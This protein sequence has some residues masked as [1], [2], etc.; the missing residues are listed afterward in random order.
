M[1]D[2][3]QY[4]SFSHM[5]EKVEYAIGILEMVQVLLSTPDEELIE[6]NINHLKIVVPKAL[7]ELKKVKRE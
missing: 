5:E 3:A 7:E 6:E 4:K 2:P 1:E